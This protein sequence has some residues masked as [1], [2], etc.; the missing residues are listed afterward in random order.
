MK[1]SQNTNNKKNDK[2]TD[3]TK[4]TDPQS[5]IYICEYDDVQLIPYYDI[6]GERLTTGKLFQCPT[7][8][9]IKD[10]SFSD[11][12]RPE[13][14]ISKAQENRFFMENIHVPESQLSRPRHEPYNI[15]PADD[16]MLKGMGG[17]IVHT[18]IEVKGRI[19]RND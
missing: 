8:G 2:I 14:I 11:L 10:T 13:Q 3:L 5:D 1:F 15:H 6:K 9:I 7:C 16:D 12:K 17:H 19:V 4:A 18:R